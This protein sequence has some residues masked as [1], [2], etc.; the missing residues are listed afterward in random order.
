MIIFA[1][2]QIG[3]ADCVQALLATEDTK[4]LNFIDYIWNSGKCEMLLLDVSL[5]A[6]AQHVESLNALRLQSNKLDLDMDIM[7]LFSN[8]CP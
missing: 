7:E 8:I 1:G 3:H 2:A 4:S 6:C 5:Q